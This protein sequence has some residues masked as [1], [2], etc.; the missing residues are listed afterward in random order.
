MM[1]H[2][3]EPWSMD[4]VS[5]NIIGNNGELICESV[6]P[7][8]ARRIVACVNACA[9]LSTELLENIT[10][11]MGETLLNRFEAF[12]QQ[13]RQLEQRREQANA[14]GEKGK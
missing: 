9:G 3:K 14:V 13:L 2:T 5:G 1:E 11:V 7:K 8:D 10:E 6:T 4:A 12:N